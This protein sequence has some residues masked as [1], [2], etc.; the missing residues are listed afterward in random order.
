MKVDRMSEGSLQPPD[1]KIRIARGGVENTKN[2]PAGLVV[3][4]L[5]PARMASIATAWLTAGDNTCRKTVVM[6][7]GHRWVSLP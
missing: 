7:T 5:R 6:R 3:P 1:T 4:Y 2:L